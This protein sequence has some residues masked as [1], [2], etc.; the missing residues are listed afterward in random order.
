M[1]HSYSRAAFLGGALR[2]AALGVAPGLALDPLRAGR[3]LAARA[4]DNGK[5]IL[6]VIQLAGGNDG[7]SMVV[8]YTDARYYQLRPT[9]NIARR[10]A[11]RLDDR[12]G[13]HPNL[14][15]LKA[16]YDRG[17][18]AVVQGVGYPNPD[19]SHFRSTDIWESALPTGVIDTGW[20]GRYLDSALA[21]NTNPLKA[22]SIG[23]ILPKAFYAR[24][25]SVPAVESLADFRFLAGG[26]APTE[27]DR[28]SNAFQRI[29]GVTADIDDS[30]QSDY[31]TRV[32]L[33]D[34]QAYR[35]TIQMARVNGAAPT[36]VPY[37]DSDLARQFRLVS[38]IIA[39]NLGTRVFMVSQ[40]GY[41]T[42]ATEFSPFEYPRLM[43]ELNGAVSAF[44]T[45]MTAQ[46]RANEVLLMT[47]S[48]FGRRPLEN[49]SGGT[50]H[51]T[52]APLLVIGGAVKG[53]LYGQTPSLANLDNGNLRYTTDFRSVYSTVL[54]RWMGADPTPAVL[55]TFPAL[56]F[57]G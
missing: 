43:T 47:F 3:A 11:L 53:G 21:T 8:P 7:L 9:M 19:F 35:A 42:H 31:L 38:Q 46:G 18:V 54:A 29:S 32:Q 27:A 2:V 50:D 28:L 51:G 48:E 37:P 13:W 41:D 44:Y 36:A 24:H 1:A 52:A 20:L 14:A 34:A 5:N 33:A 39:T 25:T 40:T 56:S 55:G 16:L 17:K 26:R 23:P 30:G 57:L 15:G 45:D 49:G 12:L 10:Q 22:V 4:H 6:I